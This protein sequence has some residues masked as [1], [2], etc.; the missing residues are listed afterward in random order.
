M[1]KEQD[2]TQVQKADGYED[3]IHL[4]H[5]VSERHPHMSLAERA[6]QFLPFAALSGYDD[7]IRETA[8]YT[9]KRIEL[10]ESA[11]AILDQKLGILSQQITE[12]PQIC[13]TYFLPDEKKDGGSYVTAEGAVR[14][15]DGFSG[16]IFL[17]DGR[18][19]P[20]GDILDFFYF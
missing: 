14:K 8:R 12:H 2:G 11:K 3:I 9:G 13:V 4:P 18:K 15:I 19:I 17:E 1:K 7:V 20:V 6:A 16:T 10:D 5:H